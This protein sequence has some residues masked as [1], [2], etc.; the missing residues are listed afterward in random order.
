MEVVPGI[1]IVPLHKPLVALGELSVKIGQARHGTARQKPAR[2]RRGPNPERVESRDCSLTW[3]P[4]SLPTSQS[5]PNVHLLGRDS[6]LGE[7]RQ[8]KHDMLGKRGCSPEVVV[9]EGIEPGL[10]LSLGERSVTAGKDTAVHKVT[11]ARILLHP[12]TDACTC[13]ITD[14]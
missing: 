9:E 5:H 12:F 1:T 13:R 8:G 11:S 14:T 7:K 4:T 3:K 10:P 2:T 6:R